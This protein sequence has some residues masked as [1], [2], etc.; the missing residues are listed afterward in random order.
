M[1]REI[2][3][4]ERYLES[5]KKQQSEVNDFLVA[6][7]KQ[8]EEAKARYSLLTQ[9]IE[10][11]EMLS[12]S[13]NAQPLPGQSASQPTTRAQIT[14]R[15]NSRD[16]IAQI[17]ND[18]IGRVASRQEIYQRYEEKFGVQDWADPRNSLNMA[19]NRAVKNNQV[20]K[21]GHDEFAPAQS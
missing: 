3:V 11:V 18:D 8:L 16:R 12:G 13:S 21:L 6:L 4:D 17:I 15:T 7:Q 19:L 20:R 10:S 2:P 9:A 5:L 14:G 1:Y